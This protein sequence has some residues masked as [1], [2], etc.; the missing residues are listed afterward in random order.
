MRWVV[1]LLLIDASVLK[2]VEVL[3]EPASAIFSPFGMTV[4]PLQIAAELGLGWLVL[5]GVYWRFTRWLAVVLFG[6]FTAY[7]FYLA[8]SGAASCGCFGPIHVHPWWTCGLD[9]AVLL[10]LLVSIRLSGKTTRNSPDV[11]DHDLRSRRAGRWSMAAIGLA[12]SLGTAVGLELYIEP[13]R[14]AAD[15]GLQTAGGLVILEPERWIGRPLPI[16]QYVDLDLSQGQWIVLLHRHDCAECQAAVPAYEQLA[17][18]TAGDS[19]RIAL[20]EVPPYGEVRD[21]EECCA[22]GR[23]GDD[24]DW[25]VQTP[26]E[27]RLRDGVVTQA[28]TELPALRPVAVRSQSRISNT[29]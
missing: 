2:A 11:H 10:G 5:V 20:V 15:D 17:A 26:V 9:L 4:L 16:A 8:T 6:G 14:I 22:C 12:L 7:S 1:S 23:L 18:D 3:T 25:F 19:P 21:A 13:D 27:I 28:S 29:L 24:Q